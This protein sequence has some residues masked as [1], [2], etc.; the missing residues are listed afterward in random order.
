MTAMDI[1]EDKRT[2]LL[3]WVCSG[4][5]WGGWLHL[6]HFCC[7]SELNREY[8]P[9]SHCLLSRFSRSCRFKQKLHLSAL[10]VVS[11]DKEEEQDENKVGD[12]LISGRNALFF[13]LASNP[14]IIEF[15]WVP[16][17]SMAGVQHKD[18]QE[19]SGPLS[20]SWMLQDVKMWKRPPENQ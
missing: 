6:E 8:K 18:P 11:W 2:K 12:L 17:S 13:I 15:P 3:N 4:V 9:N 5:S 14:C 1:K 19:G 20:N 16:P 7:T 10:G